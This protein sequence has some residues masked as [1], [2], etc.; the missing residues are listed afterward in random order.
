VGRTRGFSWPCLVYL[1]FRVCLY[2]ASKYLF[3]AV[4][5]NAANPPLFRALLATRAILYFAFCFCNVQIAKVAWK[6]IYLSRHDLQTFDFKS[7]VSC[8]P[9][10]QMKEFESAFP[11]AVNLLPPRFLLTVL[12]IDGQKVPVYWI[13]YVC[14]EAMARKMS[15]ITE[16]PDKT[17]V[18]NR[19]KWVELWWIELSLWLI[20]EVQN[21]SGRTFQASVDCRSW[22][23]GARVDCTSQIDRPRDS[24]AFC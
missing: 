13:H 23:M 22:R 4:G 15:G 2:V 8:L 10:T 17:Q 1:L 16:I 21:K 5:F 3:H 9:L 11:R 7:H 12:Q 18:Q 20:E 19:E 24:N 6:L 14:W